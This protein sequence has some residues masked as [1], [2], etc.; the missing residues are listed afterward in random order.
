[1]PYPDLINNWVK[2]V[3]P[4]MTRTGYKTDPYPK[5]WVRFGFDPS[6]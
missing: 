3:D 4:I 5:I 1:M 2:R 6:Y